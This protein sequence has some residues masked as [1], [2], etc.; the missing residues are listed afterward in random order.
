MALDYGERFGVWGGLSA[1]E[2]RG[3]LST[4]EEEAGR[5]V[6]GRKRASS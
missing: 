2:R 3:I 1:G 4:A 5:A 6:S